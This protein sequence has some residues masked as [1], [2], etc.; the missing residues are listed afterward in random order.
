MVNIKLVLEYEGTNYY[1]WQIQPDVPTVQGQVQEALRKV[2]NREITL[3][4]AAR[5]DRGVHA[6]GQVVNFKVSQCLPSVQLVRAINSILPPDI[7]VKKAEQVPDSFHARH[8]A[9][10]KVYQYFIYNHFMISPWVRRFSWWFKVPLNCE[11]MTEA[12]SYL[13][14][15]HDFSS[16]QNKGS[17]SSS[18][19]RVVEKIKINKRGFLI[20]IQLRADGFLYKMVRNITGTLVEVG[21]G[22][23]SPEDVYEILKARDRKKAGPTAPPQG[24]FLWQVFYPVEKTN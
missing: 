22:K 14:G 7:R 12:A 9:R 20:N 13:I 16:F 19:V 4:S 8:S 10:C 2:L 11:L 21:R 18:S 5:T 17:P 3:V 23:I 1:G 24:L 15:K 6:K